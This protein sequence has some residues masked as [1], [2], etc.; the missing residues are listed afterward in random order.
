MGVEAQV[1]VRLLRKR[2]LFVVS[3]VVLEEMVVFVA[4]V[5]RLP[6]KL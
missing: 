1:G 3:V 5:C 2:Q 4:V 6:L